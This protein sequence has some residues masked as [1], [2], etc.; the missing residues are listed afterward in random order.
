MVLHK[1][2]TINDLGGQRKSRK[3]ISEAIHQEKNLKRP[4]R[5]KKFMSDIF[6]TPTSL[7]ADP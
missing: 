1:G 4:P 5:G 2:T 7:M 3:Q 6:S